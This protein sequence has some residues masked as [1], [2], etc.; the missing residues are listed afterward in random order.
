MLELP[1]FE[2]PG[3]GTVRTVTLHNRFMTMKRILP[4]SKS[5]FDGVQWALWQQPA[6]IPLLV[7]AFRDVVQPEE[8]SVGRTLA[9][10]K[11]WLVDQWTTDETKQAVAKHPG[12]QAVKTPADFVALAQ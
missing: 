2:I 6:D 7:A 11:G 4:G 3:M 5:S 8:E 10:L 1:A 9:I 12:A